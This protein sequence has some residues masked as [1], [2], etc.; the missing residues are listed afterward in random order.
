MK[1]RL[2]R[3]RRSR[4]PPDFR[5]VGLEIRAGRFSVADFFDVN[6]VGSDSHLQFMNWTVDNNGGYDYAADTRGYTYGILTEFWDRNYTVRFGETLMPK[7]ANGLELD[8]N[9]ARARAENL[10]WE[11]RHRLVPNRAGT[12][13]LLSY[14]NHANMGS[15]RDSIHAFQQ[16]HEAQPDVV[17]TR[18]QGRIKYGFGVNAEQELTGDLRVFGR[19][20]WNEGHNESFAYTEVNQTFAGGG[21]L[22]GSRWHRKDDK[23]GAAY[24]WNAICRRPSSLPAVRRHR[25]PAGGRPPQLRPR[26]HFRDVLYIHARPRVRALARCAV[27]C[28]SRLQ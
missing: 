24:V 4:C 6:S 16:G 26:A 7:V 23:L 10:E 28:E 13:R 22:R 1:P 21:D 17:A 27:H 18:R 25:V 19:F 15:Y 11:L 2:R 14:V 8:W 5:F 20:G 3:E 9:I 12:V